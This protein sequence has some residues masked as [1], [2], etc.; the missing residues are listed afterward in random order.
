MKI[1]IIAPIITPLMNAIN[2]LPPVLRKQRSAYVLVQNDLARVDF[3]AADLADSSPHDSRRALA[4]L[5]YDHPPAA[6]TL[7][8]TISDFQN[9]T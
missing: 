2:I 9:T 6:F 4:N 8:C 7:H 5:R 1:P 3:F